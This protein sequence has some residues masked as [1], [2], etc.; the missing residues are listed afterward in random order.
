M[1][2][3]GDPLLTAIWAR[4]PTEKAFPSPERHQWLRMLELALDIVYGAV[5]D[6]DGEPTEDEDDALF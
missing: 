5:P 6:E 1:S 2:E 4:L 3:S